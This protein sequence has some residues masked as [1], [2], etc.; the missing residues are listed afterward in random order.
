MKNAQGG[1]LGLPPPVKLESCHYITR[2]LPLVLEIM[3]KGASN[4]TKKIF[5]KISVVYGEK[6]GSSF[7]ITTGVLALLYQISQMI[8]KFDILV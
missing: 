5:K 3:H 4:P 7:F 6:L 1:T 2:L 8:K